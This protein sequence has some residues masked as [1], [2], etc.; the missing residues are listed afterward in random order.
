MHARRTHPGFENHETWGTRHLQRF[1]KS[2]RTVSSVCPLF[3]HV[4]VPKF[5]S[6]VLYSPNGLCQIIHMCSFVAW[7]SSGLG[8]GQT[9]TMDT[10]S[11]AERSER[12][13]LIR[14]RDTKPEL[15]VRRLVYR[16]GFRYRLHKQVLPGKP[17]L[18][19]S[20]RKKVIFVHG[21]FWHRHPGCALARL[22]KSR[23]DFWVPKLSENRQRDLR[24]IRA[25]RRLG[26]KTRVV[27]E[28]E[29]HDINR[30]KEHK[31]LRF[32]EK[33]DVKSIELFTGG[34]GLALG[35]A[36][37]GFQHLALVER[38]EHSCET[39]RENQRR[40]VRDMASW[41]ILEQDI[42]QFDVVSI[43]ENIEPVGR[44]CSVSTILHRWKTSRPGRRQ[45][46]VSGDGG[47]C[48]CAETESRFDRKCSRLKA[49]FICEVLRLRSVDGVLSRNQTPLKRGVVRSP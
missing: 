6:F 45:E 24:N 47:G 44:W 37:A 26:W 28:C 4:H 35:L 23:L 20:S 33:N 49:A 7:G 40:H 42:E 31:I 48:A 13:A 2:A 32:L 27:W 15:L 46:H 19:F 25:L 12:M 39:L 43:P 5:I 21:C 30:R 16:L 34:G 41:R 38:D 17:D 14:G 3:I 9:L 36:C 11:R 29:L 8:Y 1:G 18:V 10:L 22:P